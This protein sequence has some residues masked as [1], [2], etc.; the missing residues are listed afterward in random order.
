MKKLLQISLAAL[1][2]GPQ[3]IFAQPPSQQVDALLNRGLSSK[4]EN[5]GIDVEQYKSGNISRVV[6]AKQHDEFAHPGYTHG[7]VS[8]SQRVQKERRMLEQKEY[9]A[10]ENC[11]NSGQKLKQRKECIKRV[12]R[13]FNRKKTQLEADPEQ[14]FHKSR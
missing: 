1:L 8:M 13:Q 4:R 7:N 6:A 12:I 11:R 10:K 14:Y 9:A 3:V 2:L 5:S